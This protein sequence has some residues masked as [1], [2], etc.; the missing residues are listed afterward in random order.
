M[1]ETRTTNMAVQQLGPFSYKCEAWPECGCAPEQSPK[2]EEPVFTVAGEE[3][4]A[5]EIDRSAYPAVAREIAER[6]AEWDREK[7]APARVLL[8]L[9]DG[10][11]PL[12]IEW[13]AGYPEDVAFGPKRMM[14]RL[15][16]W[17]DAHFAA[18]LA[19]SQEAATSRVPLTAAQMH[20]DE[21]L[22]ALKGA[23]EYIDRLGGI[24][25]GIRTL[26]AQV[27]AASQEGA[28]ARAP[29]PEGWKLLKDT[30]PAEREWSED[31][32]H[33]NG[34]YFNACCVC[35]RQFVG[36]KRRAV[37]KSCAAIEAASQE[38]KP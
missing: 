5:N 26:T 28:P 10:W 22:H 17:L 24:S 23:S 12:T 14:D 4:M 35:L 11:V 27:E 20:A 13:E 2:T 25:R 21:L 33:E 31:A 34:R 19:A 18:K 29:I 30:T 36:H 1:T 16:K 8:T 38:G 32:D 7:A 3:T 37:C 9:P 6:R 15:K